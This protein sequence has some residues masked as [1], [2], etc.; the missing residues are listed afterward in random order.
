MLLSVVKCINN[1]LSSIYILIVD[2]VGFIYIIFF[3]CGNQKKEKDFFFFLIFFST[4]S[5][6]LLHIFISSLFEFY[7]FWK[8][9][10]KYAF[11]TNYLNF[12][13]VAQNFKYYW[14]GSSLKNASF[15]KRFFFFWKVKH[16]DFCCSYFERDGASPARDYPKPWLDFLNSDH[17]RCAKNKYFYS[18]KSAFKD[19]IIL[20]SKRNY[21]S[22][23][24]SI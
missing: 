23:T 8:F 16:F 17:Q 18:N 21:F 15:L 12:L 22:K 13:L 9:E 1:N 7:I 4:G 20:F 5:Y 11:Q 2:Y 24:A 3:M 19:N 14:I 10:N 6:S